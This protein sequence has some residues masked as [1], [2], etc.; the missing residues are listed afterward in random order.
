MPLM[1]VA[2][3]EREMETLRREAQAHVAQSHA[4]AERAERDRDHWRA[5]AE[6]LTDQLAV[7]RKAESPPL[8]GPEESVVGS[9]ADEEWTPSAIERHRAARQAGAVT[10]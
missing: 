2:T 6:K 9:I 10:L 5:L 1:T 4:I 3:H 8:P 7:I